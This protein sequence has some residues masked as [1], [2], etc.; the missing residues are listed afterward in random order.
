MGFEVARHKLCS[1]MPDDSIGCFEFW[2]FTDRRLYAATGSPDSNLQL[3]WPLFGIIK[4]LCDVR[5]YEALH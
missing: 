1:T 4:L 3:N 5:S 2:D